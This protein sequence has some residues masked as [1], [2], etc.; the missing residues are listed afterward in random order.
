MSPTI[1]AIESSCDDTSAAVISGGKVLANIVATQEVHKQYGGV[2][3][4]LASR[5]HQQN[6]VPVVTQALLTA[7]ITKNDLDAVAFTRGPG[8]LGALL[9]GSSFAKAFA[10]GLQ[11]T[12]IEVN[13]MQAHILA[14]F[15]DEPKP[16]FPF[17][18]LTV[19]G[20]HTQIVLVKDYLQMQVLGQTTDDAVGEAF[21][22]SAKLLGLPYPGGPLLDRTAA[23]GN[24]DRF[25][26]PIVSMPG[27]DYSFS[28]I[29]TSI[30]YFLRENTTKNPNFIAENLPDICASIQ[31]ALIKTLLNKLILAAKETGIR[32]IAIAGGVSANSGL[33]KA[34]TE[35]ATKYN[36]QVYIPDF[37]Y[38]TDNA[39]M[40]AIAA[41]YKFLQGEFT[42]QYASPDPRYKL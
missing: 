28:G 18:C 37:Q 27:Y 38:C 31:N 33:R 40:I 23:T 8:L 21:D 34:L 29:K 35:A 26:F 16:Q 3:P 24:P 25:T 19:S 36:W 17:L 13:H 10:L 14:H 15:I 7:K 12:L 5:A 11:L 22:K 6:I 32:Q 20:G 30:L 2:V 1:L 39:A 42:D 41:H 9:V 4:E